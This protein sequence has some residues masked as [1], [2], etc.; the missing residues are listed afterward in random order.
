[1]NIGPYKMEIQCVYACF[2]GYISA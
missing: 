1:M 2:S